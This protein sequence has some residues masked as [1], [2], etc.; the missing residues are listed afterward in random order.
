MSTKNYPTQKD[1]T[2]PNPENHAE[3]ICSLRAAGRNSELKKRTDRP[4][5]ACFNCGA[6]ANQAGDLCA[7]TP[8]DKD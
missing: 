7:P 6:K 3:H 1:N 5:F 4:A 8:L 2:C